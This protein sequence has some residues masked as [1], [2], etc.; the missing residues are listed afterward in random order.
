[1]EE[2]S[3]TEGKEG[4]GMGE[5]HQNTGESEFSRKIYKAKRIKPQ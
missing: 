4:D 3:Q 2:T 1:M 5:G